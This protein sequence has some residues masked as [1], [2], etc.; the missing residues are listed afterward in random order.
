MIGGPRTPLLATPMGDY[1]IHSP[2]G[3]FSVISFR[4]CSSVELLMGRPASGAARVRWSGV[5]VNVVAPD[6]VMAGIL[7]CHR[8]FITLC[9]RTENDLI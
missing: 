6:A 1:Y 4:V 2:V 5:T 7:H 3:A 9:V 8:L